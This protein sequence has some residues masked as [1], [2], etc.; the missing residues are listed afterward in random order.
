MLMLGTHDLTVKFVSKEDVIRWHK[1][2]DDSPRIT[3][4]NFD[5]KQA[6][7]TLAENNTAMVVFYDPV[8]GRVDWLAVTHDIKREDD[9]SDEVFFARLDAIWEEEQ[10]K[11]LAE[12]EQM[13]RKQVEAFIAWLFQMGG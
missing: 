9:E 3:W 12:S 4:S 5:I 10:R 11:A 6:A 7:M 13:L 8:V 1:D 2:I